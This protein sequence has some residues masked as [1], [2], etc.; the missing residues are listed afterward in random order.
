MDANDNGTLKPLAGVDGEAAFDE[1]WQAQAL[2]IADTL[3]HNGMFSAGAWSQAL[4]Q[5][6]REAEARGAEDD[7]AS[8]YQCVLIA[9][10]RLIAGNSEIDPQAMA[11]KRADW[12]KAYLSTPH[13]QPVELESGADR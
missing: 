6:L 7:Q 9:L 11:A 5:A 10:E 12:E 1:A 2:A 4:G 8:Y 13:G 3:V